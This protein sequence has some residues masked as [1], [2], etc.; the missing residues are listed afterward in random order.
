MGCN[1]MAGNGLEWTRT[2]TEN[3]DRIYAGDPNSVSLHAMVVLRG[4]LYSAPD[5]LRFDDLTDSYKLIS[6]HESRRSASDGNLWLPEI[7]FRVVLRDF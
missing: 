7:G 2:L 4:R 3:P 1:D 6:F 5:P